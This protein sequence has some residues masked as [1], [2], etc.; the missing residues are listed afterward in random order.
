MSGDENRTWSTAHRMKQPLHTTPLPAE[1]CAELVAESEDLV[2]GVLFGNRGRV[3]RLLRPP[4]NSFGVIAAGVDQMMVTA[5]KSVVL[6]VAGLVVIIVTSQAGVL[7]QASVFPSIYA[8]MTISILLFAL[9]APSRH[10]ANTNLRSRVDRASSGLGSIGHISEHN[11]QEV[12]Q[13]IEKAERAS[14]SSTTVMW[15]LPG[16]AWAAGV[17]FVQRGVD[18]VDGNLF[19]VAIVAFLFAAMG[20]FVLA[21]HR[22]GCAVVYAV[23]HGVLHLRAQV[24]SD[25]R[26]A[27][28]RRLARAE[29]ARCHAGG[30]RGTRAG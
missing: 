17:Y 2:S 26:E 15:W 20:A 10:A 7:A 27:A 6:G 11:I 12:R 22:R 14:A 25:C 16:V 21:A 8:W 5:F 3:G 19:A 1:L 9:P 18:K 30:R 24:L 4:L 23:A 13:C 29:R 28:G